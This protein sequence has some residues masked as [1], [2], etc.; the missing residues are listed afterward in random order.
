MRVPVAIMD[1]KNK[2]ERVY[3]AD[4]FKSLPTS[5]PVFMEDSE[6][7]QIG[8]ATNLLIENDRLVCAD[9]TLIDSIPK[10]EKMFD[11]A[12]SGFGNIEDG[13]RV[14]EYVP[15]SIRL[16]PKGTTAWEYEKEKV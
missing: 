3:S 5:L 10:I 9:I 16:Y 7:R 13:R 15:M 6:D 8:T 12:I 11:A 2:N 14:T 4:C 1:E